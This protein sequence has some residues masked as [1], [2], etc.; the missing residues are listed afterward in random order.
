[1]DALVH[2]TGVVAADLCAG[3]LAWID[4]SYAVAGRFEQDGKDF[5]VRSSSMRLFSVPGI[6]MEGV[7]RA[8]SGNE[9]SAL[10]ERELGAPVVCDGDQ[11]WVRRQYAPGNYPPLHAPHS[12]HQ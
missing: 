7:S 4:R 3:W 10:C 9:L 12:W 5:S 2:R 1:M 6:D 8:M 11:C